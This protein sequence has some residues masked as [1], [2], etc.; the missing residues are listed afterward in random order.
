MK[1]L[2][3]TAKLIILRSCLTTPSIMEALGED[4]RYFLDYTFFDQRLTGTDYYDPYFPPTQQ[5]DSPA[6]FYK[7][8]KKRFGSPPSTN[9]A[10]RVM[11]ACSTIHQAIELTN[12]LD[13]ETINNVMGI[14]SAKSIFGPIG[15][16]AGLANSPKR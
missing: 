8:Y 1:Q 15:K 12:S 2:K 14:F 4:A 3:V 7:R 11:A 6:L 16:S 5:Y 10:P 13:I 9:D